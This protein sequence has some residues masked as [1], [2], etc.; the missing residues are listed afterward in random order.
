MRDLVSLSSL[1]EGVSTRALEIHDALVKYT[2]NIVSL[3]EYTLLIVVSS[4]K[5]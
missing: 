5:L 3:S 2:K 1:N 4:S